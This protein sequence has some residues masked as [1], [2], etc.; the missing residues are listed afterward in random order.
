[1]GLCCWYLSTR[2]VKTTKVNIGL[3]FPELDLAKRDDLAKSSIQETFKTMFEMGAVW[4]WPHE[5]LL[6]LVHE[7]EGLEFLQTAFAEGKGVVVLAPHMGNWEFLGPFLNASDCGQFN[8]MYQ[9]PKDKVLDSF[10]CSARSRNGIKLASATT[11]GV[12]KV[13][14]A[15]RK[16]ELVGILPD[17]VPSR[18]GGEYAQFFGVE[19]LTMT[20]PSR[21]LQKTGARVILAYAQRINGTKGAGVKVVFKEVESSVYAS[22]MLESLQAI[23]NTVEASV[24]ELPGQYQWEYKRFKRQPEGKPKIY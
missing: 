20:L 2:M 18:S 3:C 17:Q 24:R 12:A 19:A 16:G 4:F 9:I 21:L 10:I 11:K 13:L 1:M 15:L 23:N 22:N 8:V 7:V 6:Q 14:Q 5:K